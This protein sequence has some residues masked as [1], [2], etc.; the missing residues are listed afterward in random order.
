MGNKNVKLHCHENIKFH[1]LPDFKLLPKT[2]SPHLNV[3][4][5]FQQQQQLSDN[6]VTTA[7]RQIESGEVGIHRPVCWTFA[8]LNVI[9]DQ[10]NC[11]NE[12]CQD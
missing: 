9:S 7:L 10:A 3:I 12:Q 4:L 5:M 8:S 6:Q 11:R 2:F 1:I